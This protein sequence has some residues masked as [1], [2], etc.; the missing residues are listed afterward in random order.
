MANRP[1]TGNGPSEFTSAIPLSGT[2]RRHS[3]GELCRL[4]GADHLD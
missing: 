1:A 2:A 3:P 4:N